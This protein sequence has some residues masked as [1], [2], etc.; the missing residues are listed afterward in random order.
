MPLEAR[1]E[2]QPFGTTGI[3]YQGTDTYESWNNIALK[4]RRPEF[5]NLQR[6]KAL[7]AFNGVYSGLLTTI[8]YYWQTKILPVK[9]IN[10]TA[11]TF[12]FLKEHQFFSEAFT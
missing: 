8:L 2:V 6:M 1:I 10:L 3:L 12:Y 11:Y 5:S 7:Q 9:I 4:K